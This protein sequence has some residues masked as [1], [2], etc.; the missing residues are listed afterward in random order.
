MENQ[1]QLMYQYIEK[2]EKC[3]FELDCMLRKYHDDNCAVCDRAYE[4]ADQAAFYK[5]F[6]SGCAF[7]GMEAGTWV[8]QC[9]KPT[10]QGGLWD[11]IS[12]VKNDF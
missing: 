11:L 9:I 7:S 4:S 2:L 5:G 12:P 8:R 3:K 10:K 6:F 1:I